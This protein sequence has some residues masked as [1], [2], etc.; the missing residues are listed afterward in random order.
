[1]GSLV[2]SSSYGHGAD[3]HETISR[4]S[5]GDATAPSNANGLIKRSSSRL[6]GAAPTEP[7]A[8]WRLLDPL[9]SPRNNGEALSMA[10]HCGS[11]R[12]DRGRC[13]GSVLGNP[14]GCSSPWSSC[15][16]PIRRPSCVRRFERP[17]AI[18][19]VDAGHALA[20]PEPARRDSRLTAPHVCAKLHKAAIPLL[21]VHSDE[22]I[23]TEDPP[24][25]SQPEGEV[26][27]VP[28]AAAYL[29][30]S[31]STVYRALVAGHLSGGKPTGPRG[32]WRLLRS[33]LERACRAPRRGEKADAMPATQSRRTSRFQSLVH[34][35]TE[36]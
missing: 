25:P 30:L 26:L 4:Q 13:A 14:P 24:S 7:V 35:R 10:C 21:T 18:M 29:G 9:G 34:D 22:Q 20:C 8:V 17:P 36:T 2:R 6:G 19:P 5:W 15:R 12:P 16:Q 28:Q 33:D 31:V 1:V 23:Q 11:A 3:S 27:T 32:Q